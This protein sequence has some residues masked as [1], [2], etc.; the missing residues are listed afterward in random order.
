MKYPSQECNSLFPPSFHPLHGAWLRSAVRRG[1]EGEPHHILSGW[2]CTWRGLKRLHLK[3]AANIWGHLASQVP[4]TQVCDPVPWKQPR[5]F[6]PNL[7]IVTSTVPTINTKVLVVA[8]LSYWN[9]C[10][11]SVYTHC[12][13]LFGCVKS[14]IVGIVVCAWSVHI[15]LSLVERIGLYILW[16]YNKNKSRHKPTIS[17]NDWYANQTF[18]P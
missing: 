9:S 6:L 17:W 16:H 4:G 12:Q 18:T 8:T 1:W 11:P 13:P 2:W 10:S 7:K 15:S 5:H 3:T 14:S